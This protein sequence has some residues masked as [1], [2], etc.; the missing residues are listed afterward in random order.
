MQEQYKQTLKYVQGVLRENPDR[1]LKNMES[2]HKSKII[3]LFI[4]ETDLVIPYEMISDIDA[5][6][7]RAIARLLESQEDHNVKVVCR[8]MM[9]YFF[10][11]IEPTIEEL[12][13]IES[14]KFK[15]TYI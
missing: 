14:D 1:S 9:D 3:N 10:N 2:H 13:Q 8:N 6:S 15:S 11:S 5:C 12:L 7:I 4:D